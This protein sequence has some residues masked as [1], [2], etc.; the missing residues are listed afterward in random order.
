MGA[1]GAAGPS[2]GSSGALPAQLGDPAGM[3]AERGRA[4]LTREQTGVSVSR[5]QP[6][7]GPAMG[8]FH[9]DGI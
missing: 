8:L 5:F 3:G 4:G 1:G 7:I 2:S 9:R 6:G